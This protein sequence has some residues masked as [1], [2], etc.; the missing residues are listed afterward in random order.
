M[1]QRK[2]HIVWLAF[3][4]CHFCLLSVFCLQDSWGKGSLFDWS[5]CLCCS[6]S[7]A[8]N[9]WAADPAWRRHRWQVRKSPTRRISEEQVEKPCNLVEVSLCLSSHVLSSPN[10]LVITAKH[11]FVYDRDELQVDL[12]E[13]TEEFIQ[14][15][16]QNIEQTMVPGDNN[17][18]A[19]LVTDGENNQL[20]SRVWSI[21]F[22]G[23]PTADCITKINVFRNERGDGAYDIGWQDAQS[24]RGTPTRPERRRAEGTFRC[25]YWSRPICRKW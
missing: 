9:D 16:L 10:S 18:E 20:E 19:C 8:N 2:I 24:G 5:V 11:F 7:S 15:M 3:Q 23:K 22:S 4:I 25:A 6:E 21:C 13:L 1:K 14:G 17:Y 12:P